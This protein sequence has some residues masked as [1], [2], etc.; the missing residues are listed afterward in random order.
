MP[1]IFDEKEYGEVEEQA[2]RVTKHSGAEKKGIDRTQSGTRDGKSACLVYTQLN[3]LD[4]QFGRWVILWKEEEGRKTFRRVYLPCGSWA[5]EV[6]AQKKKRKLYKLIK[7]SCPK[8]DFYLLTLTLRQ[9]DCTL[10]ENWHRLSKCWNTLLSRLRRREPKLKYFR[11]VELQKNGMPHI[12]A[13]INLFLPEKDIQAIWQEITGD[14]HIARFERI[15][16]SS[17][18]YILKYFAKT[19]ID[20]K[21]IREAT[22]KR[23]KLFVASRFLLVREQKPSEWALWAW[24]STIDLAIRELVDIKRQSRHRW[25]R[26]SPLVIETDENGLLTLVSFESVE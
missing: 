23:T 8:S 14:S 3:A 6:C 5:C 15:K 24:C 4:C 9:N 19:V 16:Y 1:L 12:H 17:A 18:G 26:T 11:V 22:G 21:Y 13:L 25:G 2:E 7:N 10:L 20:I